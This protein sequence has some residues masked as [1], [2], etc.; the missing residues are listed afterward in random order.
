LNVGEFLTS[1]PPP[2]LTAPLAPTS[3]SGRAPSVPYIDLT[4]TDRAANEEG[5][6]V[7]RCQGSGCTNFVVIATLGPDS[8]S[9]RDTAPLRRK[10]YRYRVRAY[11][12]T[13][14]S[15]YSNTVKVK[16]K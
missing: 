5:Y 2:P 7:E 1:A 4:W 6:R 16:S 14:N 3:L 8:K 11:N 9:Y 13:G 15:A 12:A 10:A